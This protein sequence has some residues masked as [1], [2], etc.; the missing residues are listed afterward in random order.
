[1]K[2]IAN[3]MCV[4]IDSMNNDKMTNIKKVEKL[5]EGN[6]QP[7]QDLIIMPEF[8]NSGIGAD[9]FKKYAELVDSNETFEYFS[10]I[11]KKYNTY[12]LLGSLIEKEQVNGEWKQYNTSILIDR[13]GNLIAKYRKIH[14]FNSMGGCEHQY[15]TAGDETVVVE[16]DF[17]KIGLAV[18]FDMKYPQHF[19]ELISKGAEII[20]LPTAWCIPVQS[21]EESTESWVLLNRAKAIDNL[22]Y[23]ISSNTCE[24]KFPDCGTVGN[25]MIT[26]PNGKILAQA[27]EE[28]GVIFAQIDMEYLRGLRKNFDMEGLVSWTKN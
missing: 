28:E 2:N 5:I 20:T 10:K 19:S 26:A 24:N 9:C 6:I 4:Q 27:G 25:S 21:R 16:T 8:F 11:A 3:I 1:M 14:L 13:N 18:C 12:I 23:L 17:G 15:T 7:F 22:V